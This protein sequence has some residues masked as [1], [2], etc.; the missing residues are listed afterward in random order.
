M[1]KTGFL[2]AVI[3]TAAF[4][5]VT[6]AAASEADQR[7]I[8]VTGQGEVAAEPDMAVI[9][10]GVTHEAKEARAAMAAT[11]TA[12]AAMLDRLAEKGIAARDMQT[13]RLTLS[14]VWSQKRTQSGQNRN[15]ITGFSAS[16]IVLVRV[17]DLDSLGEVLDEVLAEGVNEFNGLQF[18]VQEPEPLADAARRAAVADA[19]AK[20]QLL[21]E[22][23]GVTLGP[24]M[25]MSEHG[26]RPQPV[27]MES[28]AM[29]SADVPVAGGEV[30][31]QASVS[32]VFAIAE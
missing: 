30:T 29:R 13:Q 5:A 10:M 12:V 20:A 27:M 31:V 26:G 18:G 28:A 19:M 14:P 24:V 6:A 17:R 8:T 3:L 16:N 7:T 23:A 4:V 25:T 21:A 32:M 9:R 11:S 2:I 15:E 1:K 22:A